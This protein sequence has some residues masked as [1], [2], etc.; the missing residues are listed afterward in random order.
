MR[1]LVLKNFVNN[2]FTFKK[3]TVNFLSSLPFDLLGPWVTVGWTE[4]FL[5]NEIR[6]DF[7]LLINRWSSQNENKILATSANLV[8]E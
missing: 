8:K 2:L 3:L 6:N 7:D 1:Y 5:D 4:L